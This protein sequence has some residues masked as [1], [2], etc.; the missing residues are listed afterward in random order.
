MAGFGVMP[1]GSGPYGIGTP[2][3]TAGRQGG[4]LRGTLGT[5]FGSRFIDPRTRR[6]VFDAFGRTVGMRN[7][8]H[9]L[10]THVLTELGSSSWPGGLPKGSGVIGASFVSQRETDV[11]NA[12]KPLEDAGLVEVLR[13]FVERDGQS[14]GLTRVE[15]RDLT[16]DKT[17][18]TDLPP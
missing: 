13:V 5:Q 16:T 7:S 2:T 14:R 15:W 18:A 9:M 3:V 4:A 11:R 1:A 8:A 10:L 6:W 17:E 12:L